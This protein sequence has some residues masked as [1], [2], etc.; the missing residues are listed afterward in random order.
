MR[1][2][3]FLFAQATNWEE[4]K[5]WIQTIFNLFRNWPCVTSCSWRA[6]VNIYIYIYICIYINWPCVKS[7]TWRIWVYICIYILTQILIYLID[8]V[9]N[10]AHGWFELY[11]YIYI[12]TQLFYVQ[13][14]TQGQFLYIYIYIYIWF[15]LVWFG[16]LMAYQPLWDI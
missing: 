7:C 1:L 16:C 15:G 6:W 10:P 11:I 12:L 13:D 3:M 8:F 2:W 9:L 14:L 4:G 5:F